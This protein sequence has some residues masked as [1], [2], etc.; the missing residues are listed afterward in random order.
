MLIKPNL[1]KTS[2]EFDIQSIQEIRSEKFT[3]STRSGKD[4]RYWGKVKCGKNVTLHDFI[5]FVL[6][7][8]ALKL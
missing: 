3:M 5:Y 7:C 8:T 2:N 4:S 6:L 1:K